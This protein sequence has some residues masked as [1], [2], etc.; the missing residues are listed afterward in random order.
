MRGMLSGVR[1]RGAWLV[2]LVL[3]AA[4]VARA[5]APDAGVGQSELP[6]V[7]PPPGAV[8]PPPGAVPPPPG[9]PPPGTPTPEQ[10]PAGSVPAPASGP[11]AGDPYATPA[12]AEPP[13]MAEQLSAPRAPGSAPAAAPPQGYG[14]PAGAYGASPYGTPAYGASATY[15]A[16][17]DPELAE[18]RPHLEIDPDRRR[19]S[20]MIELYIAGGGWG[21]LTGVWLV[22]LGGDL[23]DSGG[24][25]IPILLGGGAAVL[26]FGIDAAT[27]GFPTGVPASIAMGGFVGLF[28][29]L[30][31][32]AAFSRDIDDEETAV[33]LVWGGA[34]LGLVSGALLGTQ[35]R[36]TTGDVRLVASTAFWGAYFTGLVSVVAE[37]DDEDAFRA[38]LGGMNAGLLL[39]FLLAPANDLDASKVMLLNAG[40][41]VGS[42]AG[43][44]IASMISADS[45]DLEPD[46]TALTVAVGGAAGLL[47]A[48]LLFGR[49]GGSD[50]ADA[51]AR[52]G[53]AMMP[54]VAPTEGG[55]VAGVTIF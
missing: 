39:G 12:D 29:G 52:A 37:A 13:T 6:P 25:A 49:D 44:L 16:S 9:T 47:G 10:P 4:N 51:S 8:P 5:Q 18:R 30:F 48:F 14:A 34:T 43:L 1:A 24:G 55:A 53:A 2:V 17:L 41:G 42:G 45:G 23:E 46:T 27:D 19:G 15:G 50:D 22:V 21:V 31:T 3:A 36:P 11:E 28:E 32:L 54:F 35:L 38:V 26:V 33:S 20:E 40:V 7:P